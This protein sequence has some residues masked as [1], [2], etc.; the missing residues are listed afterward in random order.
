MILTTGARTLLSIA[1]MFGAFIFGLICMMTFYILMVIVVGRLDPRPLIRKYFPTMLQVFSMA[2]SNAAI[3]LNIET[4]RKKLGVSNKICSLSIPLGSTL[5]MDGTCVQLAIFALSLAKIY[6]VPI[7][8]SGLITMAVTIIILSMGAPGMPGGV[9]IC[10]SVLLEQLH[11]PT[12]AVSLVMGIGPLLGMFL[13]MSNCAGDIVVTTIIAK[14]SKELDMEV[15][16][17]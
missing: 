4:A 17:K 10:L 12:E 1:G 16:N 5:N 3:P 11:V 7:S 8:N 13:C 9:V 6:G 2:S 14:T 15:Y